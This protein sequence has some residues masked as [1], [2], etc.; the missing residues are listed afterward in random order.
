[1]RAER[2][3]RDPD[4]HFEMGFHQHCYRIF[5][6]NRICW[7][8]EEFAAFSGQHGIGIS[9]VSKPHSLD[10]KYGQHFHLKVALDISSRVQPRCACISDTVCDAVRGIVHAVG[11][12]CSQSTTHGFRLVGSPVMSAAIDYS[13]SHSPT[14]A[15]GADGPTS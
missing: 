9:V 12:R 6:S 8:K 13:A 14:I 10:A 3:I 1:M 15:H 7:E 5:L 11:I 2:A 4:R